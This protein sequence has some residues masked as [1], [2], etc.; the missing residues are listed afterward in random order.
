MNNQID[1]INLLFMNCNLRINLLFTSCN[2][3]CLSNEFCNCGQ[4]R[5]LG[6]SSC[7]PCTTHTSIITVSSLYKGQWSFSWSSPNLAG[8]WLVNFDWIGSW[9]VDLTT[10][11]SPRWSP[12]TMA[13][14]K[15]AHLSRLHQNYLNWGNL[16]KE[17]KEEEEEEERSTA[18]KAFPLQQRQPHKS[19]QV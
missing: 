9:L 2:F 6:K 1:P 7:N 10:G 5:N 14:I 15:E 13:A 8:S 17:R 3:H 18:I 11:E 19:I 4:G 12:P 16:K